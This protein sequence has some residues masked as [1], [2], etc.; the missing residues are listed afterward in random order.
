MMR[1]MIVIFLAVLSYGLVFGHTPVDDASWVHVNRSERGSFTGQ[2][3]GSWCNGSVLT[4][5]SSSVWVSLP[6]P[7][8]VWG[9]GS[10]VSYNGGHEELNIVRFILLDCHRKKSNIYLWWYVYIPVIPSVDRLV[11][12]VKHSS[13]KIKCSA[14]KAIN[15]TAI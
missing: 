1:A 5:N 14:S 6:V 15:M 7:S 11:W 10:Q 3:F 13:F 12:F 2:H 4:E 8:P 9:G